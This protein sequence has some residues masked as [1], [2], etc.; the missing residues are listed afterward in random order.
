[1]R[2]YTYACKK[3]VMDKHKFQKVWRILYSDIQ[4]QEELKDPQIKKSIQQ[5]YKT[6]GTAEP[7]YALLWQRIQQDGG[8]KQ[9]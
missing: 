3:N 9:K 7:D 1:M 2:A 6:T 4:D 8:I 5:L